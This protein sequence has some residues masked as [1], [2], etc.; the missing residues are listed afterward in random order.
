MKSHKFWLKKSNRIAYGEELRII[1]WDML[2]YEL[3]KINNFK[4]LNPNTKVIKNNLYK[5]CWF[6][7]MIINNKNLKGILVE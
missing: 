1:N 7:K 4:K 5:F 2:K 6:G 3:N